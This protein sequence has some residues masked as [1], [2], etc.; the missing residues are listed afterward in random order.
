M[1]RFTI[2]SRKRM[3]SPE[4][5]ALGSQQPDIDEQIISTLEEFGTISDS[6]LELLEDQVAVMRR[7][8]GLRDRCAKGDKAALEMLYVLAKHAVQGLECVPLEILKSI[9]PDKDMWPVLVGAD[10]KAFNTTVAQSVSSLGLGCSLPGARNKNSI[11]KRETKMKRLAAALHSLVV[12][13]RSSRL[14]VITAEGMRHHSSHLSGSANA[15]VTKVALYLSSHAELMDAQAALHM[16]TLGSELGNSCVL[17]SPTEIETLKVSFSRLDDLS[18]RTFDSW[19]HASYQVLVKLT[20]NNHDQPVFGLRGLV[21]RPD[22]MLGGGSRELAPSAVRDRIRDS[23]KD[24]L[25]IVTGHDRP[26]K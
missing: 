23:L 20:D 24:A 16:G 7:V 4:L 15:K 12:A 11:L 22:A 6:G 1:M 2:Q 19:F 14:F 25:R 9:A 13:Y 5:S 8:N 26:R 17:P 18:E 3:S 10:S 21:L